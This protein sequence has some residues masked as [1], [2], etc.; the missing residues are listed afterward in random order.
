MNKLEESF[1]PEAARFAKLIKQ[2]ADD[3]D[4]LQSKTKSQIVKSLLHQVAQELRIQAQRVIR[5]EKV[6]YAISKPVVVIRTVV[7]ERG[8]L[9]D[10]TYS[11]ADPSRKSKEAEGIVEALVGGVPE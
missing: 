1:A 6:R 4:D 10:T 5:A 11:M 7:N 9:V 3:V 8:E 2:T